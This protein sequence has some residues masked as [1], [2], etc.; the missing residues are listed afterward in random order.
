[1]STN[2]GKAN[3]KSKPND[4]VDFLLKTIDEQNEQINRL[5]TK[6]RGKTIFD[7]DHISK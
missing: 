7:L 4:D 2:R 3:V 5:Q 6:F 1:M